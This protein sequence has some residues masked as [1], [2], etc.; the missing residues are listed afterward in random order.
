MF[1]GKWKRAI[2]LAAAIGVLSL[3]AIGHNSAFQGAPAPA[4][5]KVP[6]ELL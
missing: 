6:K 1:V 2:I 5:K 4:A 3:G